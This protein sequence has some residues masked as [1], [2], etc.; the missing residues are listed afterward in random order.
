MYIYDLLMGVLLVALFFTQYNLFI[1]K[2][3]LEDIQ[4][5]LDDLRNQS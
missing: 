4:K 2:K 3:Q 1:V 5:R